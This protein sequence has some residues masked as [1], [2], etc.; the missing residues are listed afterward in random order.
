MTEQPLENPAPIMPS[1]RKAPLES[2]Y[3]ALKIITLLG[4]SLLGGAIATLIGLLGAQFIF[5]L[6]ILGN[7]YVLNDME[8][9]D[10]LQAM[11]FIQVVSALGMFVLP[12]LVMARMVSVSPL[13]FLGLNTRPGLYWCLL[14]ICLAVAAG[15]LINLFG[16]LNS[17]MVFPDA[18]SGMGRWMRDKEDEAAKMTKAFMHVD[19]IKGLLVDLF[20]I[21]FLAAVGEEL[22]FR[23][24][25]QTLLKEWTGKSH[26]AIWVTAVVFSAVHVQFFGFLPRVLLGA[27]FGYLYSWSGSLWIPILGHFTNNAFGV[28][29]YYLMDHNRIPAQADTIGASREDVIYILI[30]LAISAG[31][32]FLAYRMRRVKSSGVPAGE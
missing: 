6:N 13:S 12:A 30:S 17:R 28:V 27:L 14:G 32:I 18:L 25:L 19:G 4:F 29:I 22:L 3:P 7:P 24:A 31:L 9:P 1:R 15:P 23:G 2:Q 20:I 21:A 10:V 8:R 11:K 5:H 26:L 16:E